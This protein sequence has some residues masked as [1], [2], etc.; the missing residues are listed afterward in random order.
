MI[1]CFPHFELGAGPDGFW[2]FH[3]DKV[4]PSP[5]LLANSLGRSAPGL[6]RHN[7][8]LSPSNSYIPSFLIGLF[9]SVISK[10]IALGFLDGLIVIFSLKYRRPSIIVVISSPL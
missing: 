10:S 8:N 3:T 5:C 4:R 2:R 6:L 9:T 1:V 7:V